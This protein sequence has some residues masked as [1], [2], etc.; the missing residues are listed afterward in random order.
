[1]Y[2]QVDAP[3]ITTDCK[4]AL[5]VKYVSN[6]WHALK[7]TFANEIGD[8]AR[9]LGVNGQALMDIFI[10]DTVLN[11]SP[12]YLRPG[13]PYGG[14]C[15]PKDLAALRAM[16]DASGPLLD[17]VRVSNMARISRVCYRALEHCGPRVGVVGLSFKRGTDDLRESPWAFV[18][19]RLVASGREVR[20]YDPDVPVASAGEY[21]P[22]LVDDL[23]ALT[24]WATGFV[25]G[26][27]G[28]VNGKLD[29][30]AHAVIHGDG[31]G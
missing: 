3:V 22:L 6:A 24:T 26:K 31:S 5:L 16:T 28:L 13:S 15:L 10:Q 27:P 30:A 8:V 29:R 2:D 19:D 12:A 21:A 1:L 14:S 20:V 9:I 18:V 25:I 7:V 4:T 23:E 11:I 17:A